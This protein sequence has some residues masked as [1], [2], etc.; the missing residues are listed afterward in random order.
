MSN[1]GSSDSTNDSNNS[2]SDNI[3]SNSSGGESILL[4]GEGCRLIRLLMVASVIMGGDASLV[5]R[6]LQASST[7]ELEARH[8]AE[9]EAGGHRGPRIHWILR[10]TTSTCLHLLV[11]VLSAVRCNYFITSTSIAPCSCITDTRTYVLE[12]AY[13]CT[14]VGGQAVGRTG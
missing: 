14:D 5:F 8:K 13:I 3:N 9:I 7:E 12:I 1:T 4:R 10:A 11:V 2:S 6:A